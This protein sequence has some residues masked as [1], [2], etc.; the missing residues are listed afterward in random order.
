[1]GLFLYFTS[2][3][4]QFCSMKPHLAPEIINLII[5]YQ[6]A[7]VNTVSILNDSSVFKRTQRIFTFCDSSL[8]SA[9]Q[10]KDNIF[11]LL[12]QSGA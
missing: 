8:P 3:Q 10:Y 11:H 9:R 2:L 7:W 5:F 12:I 4:I 1:M 6:S